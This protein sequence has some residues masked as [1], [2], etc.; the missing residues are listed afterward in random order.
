MLTRFLGPVLFKY[1]TKK[2]SNYFTKQQN[3]DQHSNFENVN[4]NTNTSFRNKSSN[5]DVGE[6]I[7][8]EEID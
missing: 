1:L 2:A 7:D 6:Y 3:Y 5:K 4:K 8:F